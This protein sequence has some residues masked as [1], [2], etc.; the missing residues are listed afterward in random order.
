[1]GNLKIRKVCGFNISSIHFSMMIL[2]YINKELEQEKSII[3]ILEGNLEKNIKQVL[4]KITINNE[5]KEKILNINW[6]DTDIRK[7]SIERILKT[8]LTEEKNNLDIIVYGSE[9]YINFV[10]DNISKFISKNAKTLGEKNI[11]IIDCYTVNDFNEN[12]KEILDNHDVMFN[13]S[14][15]HKIEEIFDGYHSA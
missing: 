5:S 2:P 15:E 8:E 1:M 10:N 6:K 14:G 11:K 4:S 9:K 3:T 12:I 7:S 13:T